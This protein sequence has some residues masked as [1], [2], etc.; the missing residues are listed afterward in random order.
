[1]RFLMVEMA[2]GQQI[3]EKKKM[4]GSQNCQGK[5]W[6]RRNWKGAAAK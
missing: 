2:A 5:P 6:K 3:E 4:D 1:M